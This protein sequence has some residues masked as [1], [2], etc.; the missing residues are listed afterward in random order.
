MKY[1]QSI[2]DEVRSANNIVE[3]IGEYLPLKKSGTNFKCLCPFHQEKTPSFMVSSS[4]QIYKCFGCGKG[5]NVFT[6][7]M[8][9]EKMNFPEA[10]EKLAN[11]VGIKLPKKEISAKK[12]TLY[13]ELYEIY[14]LANRFYRN[15]LAENGEDAVNYLHSRNISDGIIET[16]QIGLAGGRENELLN[17]IKKKDYKKATLVK[18]GLFIIRNG[19]MIDKFFNRIIFP[20]F[21]SDGKV[22]AFSGRIY[23]KNDE[24]AA[25]YLNSPENLIYQKRF[26]LYGLYQTKKQIIQKNFALLVEGNTD[27]LMVYQSGFRNVVASLGTSLTTNQIKLL[28]RYTKNVYIL[29]DGDNAG[30]EA[31]SRALKVCLENGIFPKIISLPKDYDPDSFLEKFGPEKLDEKINNAD[32]FYQFIKKFRKADKNLENKKIAISETIDNIILIGDSVQREM[33]IQEVAA[34]FQISTTNLIQSVNARISA[35]YRGTEK[36]SQKTSMEKFVDEKELIRIILN[37][38]EESAEVVPELELD[39]FSHPICKKIIIVLKEQKNIAEFITNEAKILDYFTAEESNFVSD[40]MF[41]DEKFSENNLQ[42]LLNGLQIK[43]L[44][45][46]LQELNREIV[47]NPNDFEKLKIKRILQKKIHRLNPSVVRKL[48]S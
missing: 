12:Q 13:G 37:F 32:S 3:I 19:K 38:P 40:L 41:S 18:S 33:Y 1:D 15:N 39:C 14:Q 45:L 26:Q 10:V 9:Y 47:E 22:I 16:F 23:K 44:N 8:E 17:F 24:R 42:K 27:L 11:R 21:S 25:K 6:F 28:A 36:T 29:Y 7:L 30:Y 2:I 5:G 48:L 20:I 4:K 43:S 35:S 46:K 31:S 34:L